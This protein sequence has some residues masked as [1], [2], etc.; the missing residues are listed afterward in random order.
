MEKGCHRCKGEKELVFEGARHVLDRRLGNR[1]VIV[2]CPCG[3]LHYR[4]P[5]S[6]WADL[7]ADIARA[8]ETGG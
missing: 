3:S 1:L 8:Q 7:E 2:K 5:L 4:L 6:Q